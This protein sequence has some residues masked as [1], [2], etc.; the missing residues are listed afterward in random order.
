M[1]LIGNMDETPMWFD[2]VPQ[3]LEFP[4]SFLTLDSFFAHKIDSVLE[5]MSAN[6]VGSLEVPA[7][8]TSKVQ[9]LDVSVNRPFKAVLGECWE[10][11]LL[12]LV[13]KL[14]A[15]DLSD[16]KFKLTP[17]TRQQI[18]D[19]VLEGYNYLLTKKDMIKRGFEVCGVT[20]T[21]P[22]RVRNDT[23]Y[24]SIMAKVQEEVKDYDNELLDDDPFEFETNCSLDI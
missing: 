10:G 7:S 19:W 24:K 9:V 11:Y 13:D 18:V 17:P 6:D 20:S 2:I 16:P 1:G 14:S 22:E 5:E 8:C 15:V 3:E 23:F 4:R 12:D 21:D